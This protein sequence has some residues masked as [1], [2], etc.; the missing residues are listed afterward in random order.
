[1][2]E[3]AIR[4]GV[5]INEFN[6]MTPKEFTL[7]IKVYNEKRK[8]KDK[9]NITNAYLGAAWQRAKKL[10]NLKRLFDQEQQPKKQ[11]TPEQMLKKVMELNKAFG[12][13]SQE[14]NVSVS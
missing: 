10:P 6:E 4:M 7:Y 5:S 9:D 14:V 11:M 3:T 1:M 13:T 12:G 8:E 2:L